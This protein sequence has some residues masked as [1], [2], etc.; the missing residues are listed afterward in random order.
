MSKI[1]SAE[2]YHY[3]QEYFSLLSQLVL[4]SRFVQ[5][6]Q[7]SSLN[8]SARGE[9]TVYLQPHAICWENLIAVGHLLVVICQ[10]AQL[11]LVSLEEIGSSPLINIGLNKGS[12]FPVYWKTICCLNGAKSLLKNRSKEC[13]RLPYKINYAWK[14]NLPNLSWIDAEWDEEYAELPQHVQWC[15]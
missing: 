8:S 15:Q 12:A 7:Y 1:N 6:F 11:P 4:F 2:E 5:I 13:W 3:P 10:Q 14:L 9:S